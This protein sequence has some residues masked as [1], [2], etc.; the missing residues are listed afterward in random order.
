MNKDAWFACT[1]DHDDILGMAVR[2]VH[3]RACLLIRLS[4]DDCSG[5]AVAR[6]GS[7]EVYGNGDDLVEV[8]IVMPDGE[9]A[10]VYVFNAHGDC[11]QPG[12]ELIYA[13]L[14]TMRKEMIL[15]DLADV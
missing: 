9:K 1:S 2:E 11:K 13:T 4:E 5:F 6:R 3:E 8:S 12:S 15:D 14:A 7:I 10:A